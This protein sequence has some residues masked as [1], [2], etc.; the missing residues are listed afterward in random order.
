MFSKIPDV[1]SDIWVETALKEEAKREKLL[2]D[3]LESIIKN[4][5]DIKERTVDKS[6]KLLWESNCTSIKDKDICDM[7]KLSWE[8][9]L[10]K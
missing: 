4:K 5:F 3:G 10:M 7:Q 8:S 9:L 1:I 6:Y 2:N